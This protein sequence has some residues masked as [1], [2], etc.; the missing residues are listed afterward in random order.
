MGVRY[1]GAEVRRVEDPRLVTGKGRYVDDIEL[2]GML[3]AVMVRSTEA[4]A[5]IRSIDAAAARA[6]PGVHAVFTLQDFPAEYHDRPMVQPYPAPVLLQPTTQHPLARDEVCFVGQAIAIVV[7]ETRHIAEDAAGLV[8]VDYEPLPAVVDCREAVKTDAPLAHAG[9]PDNIVARL[10]V[11]FG[12]VET[13]FAD[14]AHVFEERFL[15]HRGG[16]HAMECRGVIA[17]DRPLHDGLTIVSATQC[18]YLVRRNVAAY[19]GR[20]EGRV[21]VVAPDVGGGFGPKAGVYAEEIVVPLAAAAL[22]RPVKWIED[23][24]EHFV[25]TNTQ[26]DQEWTLEAAVDADGKLLGV[27]GRVIHDNGAFVPYGL[28]LPMTSLTPLPGPYA[29]PALDVAMDVVFTNT[30]P[31]S[32][33]RG[34]GR[35]NAAF[36]MERLIARVAR[37]LDLDQAEVRRRNYVPA[38]GFP[39][40]TGQKFRDGSAIKYDSGD[41]EGCLDKVV[42]LSGYAGFA[43][44]QAEARAEG[45]YLGIGVSSCIEDTGVG[46]YE[47]ATVRVQPDG[48]VQI[49]T[50][51]A[52]QGQGH[53][54]MLA[55]VCADRLD[56][57]LEDIYVRAAD[58]GAFPQGV[59]TIGSRVAVNAST[60]VFDAAESVRDKAL[61][62]AAERLEAS[63]EDLEVEDGV[64]GVAGVPEMKVTYGELAKQLAPMAGGPLPKGF[65][66][67]LEAT[68]YRTSEGMPTASGSNIAEVEVDIGTGEVRVLRYSVAHDCGKMINPMMVDG[69]IVGGVVHGIGNAL[70]ER[71][72]YDEAGQPLNNNYGEY[73]LP[74]A[75]EM[76]P[77][78]VTHQETPSPFNPLGIK[79]AGEGGTIPATAAVV[80][81]IE[82]ALEPFD[83]VIRSYPVSPEELCDLIEGGGASERSA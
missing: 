76:P 52:S 40:D 56:V 45:R 3:E 7:A 69:Q 19:L 20:D 5:R 10:R 59:G 65:S 82:N 46:P 25:T 74:I 24:R 51:A 60:A 57:A 67:G 64:I 72:V 81:A 71:L 26:R 2:P 79:G 9:S 38:D 35:P 6:L 78:A 77:I 12:E 28:L 14:A 11:A 50:G 63:V 32:P 23:R 41:F 31:N 73:L 1:F 4:H 48:K 58:T 75:T 62:L 68:S 29:V 8:A 36:A 55:Q 80:A 42:E 34:A 49:Q 15:Q 61:Q 83:V 18:P 70:F 16:C 37:E 13:A 54:T 39:Y 17:E 27:R 22:G 43:E 44:R 21:R 66:P 53:E 47:G 30:A 33:I